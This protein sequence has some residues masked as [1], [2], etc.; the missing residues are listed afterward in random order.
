[1]KKWRNPCI[2]EENITL[3]HPLIRMAIQLH[4]LEKITVN[5]VYTPTARRIRYYRH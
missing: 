3:S 4:A 2:S 1:M 5:V